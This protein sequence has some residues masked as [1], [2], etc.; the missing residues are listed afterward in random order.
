MAEIIDPTAT[1]SPKMVI[2]AQFRTKFGQLAQVPFSYQIGSIARAA[3]ERRQCG[4]RGRKSDIADGQRLFKA[5]GKT[6]LITPR[7]KRRTRGRTD[8]VLL[9]ALSKAHAARRAPLNRLGSL[10]LPTAAH[11]V[12]VTQLIPQPNNRV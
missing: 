6:I 4:M 5:D 12:S 1:K 9:I 10:I 8:G 2:A 11:H 7:S 3:E